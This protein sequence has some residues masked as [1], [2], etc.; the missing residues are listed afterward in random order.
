[1]GKVAYA[2]MPSLYAACDIAVLP[3]VWR[4]GFGLA[5]L[6]AMAAGRPV[7]AS[8]VGGIPEFVSDSNGVL[9]PPA[10]EVALQTAMGHLADDASL[11]QKL[12]LAASA[13][14]RSFTWDVAARKLEEIYQSALEANHHRT[15]RVSQGVRR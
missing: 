12:G 6:E 3:S 9:C 1:V 15:L 2:M 4:E 10:D 7:I 14:A 11:R 13:T 5:A 8:A